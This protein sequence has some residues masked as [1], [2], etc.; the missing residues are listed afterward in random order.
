[1][2][3]FLHGYKI[4]YNNLGIYAMIVYFCFM[5]IGLINDYKKYLFL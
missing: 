4:F 5:L 1:M 2:K 3:M